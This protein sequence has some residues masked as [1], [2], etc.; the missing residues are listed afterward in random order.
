MLKDYIC[1]EDRANLEVMHWKGEGINKQC[2]VENWFDDF[3][4]LEYS[5]S[6]DFAFC[7]HCYLYPLPTTDQAFI[8]RGFSNFTMRKRL[9]FLDVEMSLLNE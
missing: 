1:K 2:F 7:L 6:K 8:T 4:W 3:P 9:S 5:V